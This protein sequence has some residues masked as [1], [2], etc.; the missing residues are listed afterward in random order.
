MTSRPKDEISITSNQTYML[1]MSPVRKAP[2]MPASMRVG[3]RV[4]A[5]VLLLGG[6]VGEAEDEDGDRDERRRAPP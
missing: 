3:Q 1:K 4:V 6:D 5:V 2:Q